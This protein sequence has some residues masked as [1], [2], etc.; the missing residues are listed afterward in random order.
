MD[1]ASYPPLLDSG[2][3]TMN[4]EEIKE[5]CVNTF[6]ESKRRG[7][8]YNNFQELLLGFNRINAIIHCISEIWVD[9]SFTTEKPE[10]DD[11]DILVVL[12]PLLLNQFPEEYHGAISQLLDRKFVK[13][14]Y[15][16]DVLPLHKNT[17]DYDSMRSYW[18]G[19]FGFDRKESPKGLIRIYL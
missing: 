18:R 13:L 14:N 5:L 4:C 1:K 17:T 2:F 7:M 3:H 6:P 12:D 15:N 16:I 19:W 8:L 11:I 9:G 10:P